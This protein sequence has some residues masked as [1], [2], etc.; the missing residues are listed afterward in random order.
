MDPSYLAWLC[1]EALDLTYVKTFFNY[2]TCVQPPP[3]FAQGWNV[4]FLSVGEFLHRPF[5]GGMACS[6]G[7]LLRLVTNN[8][9]PNVLGSSHRLL[10]IVSRS[11][12]LMRS[13]PVLC[14]FSAISSELL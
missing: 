6:V 12:S 3:L 10:S 14:T 8:G 7:Y 11:Y 4:P 1:Q 5:G 13:L 2:S 9:S